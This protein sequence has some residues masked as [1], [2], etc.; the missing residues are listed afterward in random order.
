MIMQVLTTH[1]NSEEHRFDIWVPHARPTWFNSPL[2]AELLGP[3]LPPPPPPPP[4][5]TAWAGAGPPLWGRSLRP[6]S[7]PLLAAAGTA[8]RRATAARP[9]EPA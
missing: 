3:S 5:A 4:A 1:S 8:L 7:L 6:R 2:R 9:P